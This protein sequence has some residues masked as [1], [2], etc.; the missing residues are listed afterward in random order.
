M[1]DT[2][3]YWK[4]K[5]VINKLGVTP[6]KAKAYR[7]E[8]LTE[9]THWKMVDATIYWSDHALWMYKKHLTAPPQTETTEI[10]VPVIGLAANPRFV[11]GNLNGLRI[12]IHCPQA[13]SQRLLKKTIKV[14]V[15]KENGENL[16]TYTK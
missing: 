6:S 13:L 2:E 4:Q 7:D 10:E 9:D 3:T 11:Y 1:V 5:E 12:A 15:S 16:Y 8:Y 14:S